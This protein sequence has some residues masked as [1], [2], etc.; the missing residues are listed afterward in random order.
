M[1]GRQPTSVALMSRERTSYSYVRTRVRY[2]YATH[3]LRIRYAYATHTLRIRRVCRRVDATREDELLIRL[4]IR[5]AYSMHTLRIRYAYSMS[6]TFAVLFMPR[7]STYTLRILY[8]YAYVYPTYTLRLQY[9]TFAVAFMPRES[10]YTRGGGVS[11]SGGKC[12]SS[13]VS[14]CTFCTSKASK[15]STCNL[16]T[17]PC[18]RPCSLSYLQSRRRSRHTSNCR[19][20][21]TLWGERGAAKRWSCCV[22]ICTFVLVKLVNAD[23]PARSA[24]SAAAAAQQGAGEAQR[25]LLLSL[26]ALLVPKYKY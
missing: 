24:S 10:T 13:S 11:R 21:V 20:G 12:G 2:A 5:F 3:T 9:L 19:E 6:Y 4:R 23:A 17:V 7:E 15:L 16:L 14:I 1:R 22:S 18:L 25:A 8:S 26:L